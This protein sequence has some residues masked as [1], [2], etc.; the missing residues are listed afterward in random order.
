MARAGIMVGLLAAT[1]LLPPAARAQTKPRKVKLE[2]K[3]PR[4]QFVG[5]PKDLNLCLVL[6]RAAIITYGVLGI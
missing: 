3:L 5:T 4:P 1:V 6:E 2:L